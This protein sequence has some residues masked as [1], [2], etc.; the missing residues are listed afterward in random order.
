MEQSRILI[1]GAN[2]LIGKCL[3]DDLLDRGYNVVGVDNDYREGNIF[4]NRIVKQDLVSFLKNNKNNFDYIFHFAAINGTDNFYN[5]PNLVLKNNI[6]TDLSMFEFAESN[7]NTLIIYASSSEIVADCNVI[8][9]PEIADADLKNIHNPRWSYRLSK[10][11]AENYLWNSSLNFLIVRF[12]NVF[13]EDSRPGHFLYD[14][15]DKIKNE[16]HLLI[17]SEE[18]RSFC[19]VKDAVNALVNLLGKTKREIINIGNNEEIKIIEAANIIAESIFYK[20]IDWELVPSK[21]GSTQRR[22]PDISKL[23]SLYPS[24]NPKRFKEAIREISNEVYR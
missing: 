12:F 20:K 17:G 18:T 22:C 8:P 4:D 11:A 15:I 2:G 19:Y 23:L 24:Y 1:T 5:F 9:T 14:I 16:D 7:P 6:Q 21:P 10:I 13:S 3:F